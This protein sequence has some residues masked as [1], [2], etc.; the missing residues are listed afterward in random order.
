MEYLEQVMNKEK[1]DLL[2]DWKEVNDMK[3]EDQEKIELLVNGGKG[4]GGRRQEWVYMMDYFDEELMY[5]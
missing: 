5:G 3:R 4:F 2:V 1:E